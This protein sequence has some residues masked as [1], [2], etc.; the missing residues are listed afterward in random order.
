[1]FFQIF[2][3]MGVV[4]GFCSERVK[5]LV[6]LPWIPFNSVLPCLKQDQLYSV[7]LQGASPTY[8]KAR[9][10]F[11][12]IIWTFL[13]LPPRGVYSNAEGFLYFKENQKDRGGRRKIICDKFESL[14]PFL[15][16]K[17]A[18]SLPFPEWLWIT[19]NVPFDSRVLQTAHI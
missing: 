3:L 11:L 4:L 19:Q 17:P 16:G 5:V 8:I 18:S 6:V 2:L 7:P 9:C 13:P 15:F 10:Y 12:I 14:R 1:M